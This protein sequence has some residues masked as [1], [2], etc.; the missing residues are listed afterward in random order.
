[1]H[2]ISLTVLF[3]ESIKAG[4]GTYPKEKRGTKRCTKLLQGQSIKNWV[5][6][7]SIARD[8]PNR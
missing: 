8:A 7:T 5:Q 3:K 6:L 1:M 4:K 2:F